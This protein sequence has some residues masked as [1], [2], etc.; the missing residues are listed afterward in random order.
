MREIKLQ[1]LQVTLEWL[2]SYFRRG[3]VCNC[4]MKHA[5]MNAVFVSDYSRNE[6]RSSAQCL[7]I[8]YDRE[9]VPW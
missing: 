4:C 2:H 5:A 7:F 6:Q 3:F 8:E 1:V 9:L